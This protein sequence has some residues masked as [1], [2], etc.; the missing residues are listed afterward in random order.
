ME[1]WQDWNFKKSH[2]ANFL[3]KLL[4]YL[5]KTD[6]WK[7]QNYNREYCDLMPSSLDQ[8]HCKLGWNRR[9]KHQISQGPAFFD[10]SLA[11]SKP[12][13]LHAPEGPHIWI[14]KVFLLYKYQQDNQVTYTYG[15]ICAFSMLLGPLASS[16]QFPFQTS[17]HNNLQRR[18]QVCPQDRCC[19]WCNPAQPPLE[20]LVHSGSWQG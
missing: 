1:Y 9:Q 5:I 4:S 19:G 16:V 18:G 2:T 7:L 17:I 20:C 11:D 13:W 14:Q 10:S 15:N 12:T 8:W 6:V 3:L